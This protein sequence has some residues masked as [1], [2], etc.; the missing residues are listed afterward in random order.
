MIRIKLKVV[1]ADRNLTQKQL[2]EL[3]GVPQPIISQYSSNKTTALSRK[4]LNTF[5]K[6]LN[7][8]IEDLLEYVEDKEEPAD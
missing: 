3:S 6:V 4:T 8:K 1:M 2:A 7:C 5:C